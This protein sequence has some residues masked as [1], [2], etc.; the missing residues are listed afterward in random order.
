MRYP[1]SIQM[2]DLGGG[3]DVFFPD[4]GVRFELRHSSLDEALDRAQEVLEQYLQKALDQNRSIPSPSLIHHVQ[5][6][7]QDSTWIWAI[8]TPSPDI[9]SEQY[10]RINISLSRRVLTRL[11]AK[12]KRLGKSRSAMITEMALCYETDALRQPDCLGGQWNDVI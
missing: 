6:Q 1:V 10:E 2:S 3:L 9:Y 5:K 4:L 7:Y 11:D 8:V 12:A